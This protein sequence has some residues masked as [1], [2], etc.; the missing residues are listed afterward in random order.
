MKKIILMSFLVGVSCVLSVAGAFAASQL[1]TGAGASFPYPLY[2]KWFSEYKKF[3]PS[4]EINYQSI[5]SGGGVR[6]FLAGTTDFGASDAPMTE[7]EMA[8]AKVKILHIP[9]TLGAVVL[10]YN[11]PGVS[12]LRLTADVIADIF[13]GK[14]TQ[15]NDP[16]IQQLNPAANLPKD[17]PILVCHRAEG[18]GTTAVFTDYLSAVSSDWKQKF[19]A[20][21]D[22]SFPKGQLGGKGNEGV[23]GLIRQNPGSIGYIEMNYAMSNHFPMATLKNRAGVFVEPTIASVTAAALADLKKI[24]GDYRTSIVDASGK[25]SYP[26][27]AFTY[28]LVSGSMEKAKGEKIV[29][30]LKWAMGP[31]QKISPSLQYAPLPG[32]LVQRVEKTLAKI[33]LK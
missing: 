11:I 5:G 32:P 13:M 23:T 1:I 20:G 4:V 2:A 10:S 17:L 21:K 28:L 19:G 27:S 18:S 7:A 25:A 8:Q 12:T 30:F 31:G 15:W 6:Q 14:I 3:D 26:I 33:E 9:M 22:I 24:P 16:R 29:G